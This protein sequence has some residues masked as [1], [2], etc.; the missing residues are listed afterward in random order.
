VHESLVM[1]LLLPLGKHTVQ[2]FDFEQHTTWRSLFPQDD[3]MLDFIKN[4]DEVAP[5]ALGLNGQVNIRLA[6]GISMK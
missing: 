2:I 4:F 1:V 6:Q 3:V 5:L